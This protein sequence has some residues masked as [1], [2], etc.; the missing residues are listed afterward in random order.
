MAGMA[1]MTGMTLVRRMLI[2]AGM[3]PVGHM[4][5]MLALGDGPGLIIV[6]PL[7]HKM[8]L[9]RFLCGARVG[10]WLLVHSYV[11][12]QIGDR[13]HHRVRLLAELRS[14]VM[15]VL[16][17]GDDQNAITR[18]VFDHALDSLREVGD[19]FV[20]GVLSVKP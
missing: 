6:V 4:A 13:F 14:N 19:A 18:V 8:L 2:M 3:F 10:V 12:L 15:T 9:C 16:D 7:T 5:L 1:A 11:L 17:I 20:I